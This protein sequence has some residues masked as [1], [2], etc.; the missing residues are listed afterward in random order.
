MRNAMLIAS[1]TPSVYVR[2]QAFHTEN[3]PSV[4]E[5]YSL[6]LITMIS[7]QS[8]LSSVLQVNPIFPRLHGIPNLKSQIHKRQATA[9]RDTFIGLPPGSRIKG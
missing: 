5:R 3:D 2:E 1:E 7:V 8:F 9:P 6:L 4:L